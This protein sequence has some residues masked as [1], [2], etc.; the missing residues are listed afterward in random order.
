MPIIDNGIT[1]FFPVEIVGCIGEVKST[2][3][4]GDFQK[5]LICQL[6]YM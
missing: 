5:A 6:L 4:M 3:K 2:L 1:N